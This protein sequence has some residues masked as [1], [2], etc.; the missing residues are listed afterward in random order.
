MFEDASSH[1]NTTVPITVNKAA[2]STAAPPASSTVPAMSSAS[3]SGSANTSASVTPG[4]SAASNQ[5]VFTWL[6]TAACL[7]LAASLV[8]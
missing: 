4:K 6:P 3:V 8:F 5:V 7:V 1:T 2:S